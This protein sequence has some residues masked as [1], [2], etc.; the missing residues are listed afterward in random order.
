MRAVSAVDRA[1]R[2][3]SFAEQFA[4]VIDTSHEH[5]LRLPTDQ[6]RALLMSHVEEEKGFVLKISG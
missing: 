4:A 2:G 6:H 1:V 3:Q 5:Q